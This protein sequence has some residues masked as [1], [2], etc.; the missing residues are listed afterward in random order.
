[1]IYLNAENYSALGDDTFWL[2]M[3]REFKGSRFGIP[4]VMKDDDILLQYST[5]GF[6]NIAGK[7]V[8]ILWEL[9]PEMRLV[10]NDNQWDPIIAKTEE[11]ARFCTYRTVP[12]VPN[13][14]YYERFGS[15]DV[16]PIGVDTSLFRRAMPTERERLKEFYGIPHGREIGFWIGTTHPMKGYPDLLEYAAE[17][18]D[19]Y[20][21]VVWKWQQESTQLFLEGKEFTK[22][23]QR[24]LSELH[25]CS[26]FIL[27]TNKLRSY[28][29]AEWEAMSS[30]LPIRRLH[31]AEKDFREPSRPRQELFRQG[32]D[33]ESVKRKWIRY[34]EKRGISW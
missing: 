1:M 18:P 14:K 22:I 10:L 12:T 13:V 20:W 31:P 2:W 34:F 25:S 9:Y 19:I 8:A 7:T 16:M 33:R 30:D 3:R 5:L 27:H 4:R 32:W 29:M 21:I 6:P 24:Q 23:P 26:D 28:F 15:I 11:A 17:N